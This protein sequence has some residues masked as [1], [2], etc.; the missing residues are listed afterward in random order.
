[1]TFES[2][3]IFQKFCSIFATLVL[4]PPYELGPLGTKLELFDI[5]ESSNSIFITSN[6]YSLLRCF[7]RCARMRVGVGCGRGVLFYPRLAETG[8]QT[9][10]TLHCVSGERLKM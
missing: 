4:N 8:L 3:M 2:L 10:V 1:M 5:S 6:E 9:N 7:T